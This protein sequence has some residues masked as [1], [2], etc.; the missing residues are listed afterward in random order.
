MCTYYP[1]NN[2]VV[3]FRVH[4]KCYSFVR[5][6][7]RRASVL[8]ACIFL[9]YSRRYRLANIL[10]RRFFFFFISLSLCPPNKRARGDR[11]SVHCRAT[12]C[13]T[14]SVE[15]FAR[16]FVARSHRVRQVHKHGYAPENGVATVF[17]GGAMFAVAKRTG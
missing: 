7:K 9:P 14:Q 4:A 10:T 12:N 5:S 3:E 13:G 16:V 1:L 15:I 17:C 6:S 8:T 2:F 11:H